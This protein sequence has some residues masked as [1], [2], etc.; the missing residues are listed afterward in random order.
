M[1][2]RAWRTVATGFCFGVFGAGGVVMALVAAP[3]FRALSRDPWT[4]V[5]RTRTLIRHWFRFFVWLMRA[6]G[7][8]SLEVR[9]AER[10]RRHGILVL[11][12][13][14]SLIDV[15]ILGGLLPQA[16]CIVKAGL[17][18]NVFTRGPV[19]AAGYISNREG[20]QLVEECVAALRRGDNLL[21][22]PE[23]TR[24]PP[25]GSIRLQRGSAQIAVR[26]GCP[27][28]PVV[29][30]VSTPHLTKRDV[31]YRVPPVR[32]HYVV[33]VGQD[34]DLEASAGRT[35]SPGLAARRLTAWLQRYFTEETRRL[36]LA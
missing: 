1:L 30:R 8:I 14:P 16:S 32:P 20:S 12:N 31:W 17:W 33:E 5:R 10:L 35:D 13:H 15:V 7:A 3:L 2:E 36:A 19:V 28:A 25:D 24:T 26:A 34:I 22:F 23:G 4:C 6:L 29:I 21:V 18:R 27:V 11:A 9:G